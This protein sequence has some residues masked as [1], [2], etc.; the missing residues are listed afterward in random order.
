MWL[1]GRI[2]DRGSVIAVPSATERSGGTYAVGALPPPE[3]PFPPTLNDLNNLSYKDLV[4]LDEFYNLGLF[5]G[6]GIEQAADCLASC[7]GSVRWQVEIAK[8]HFATYIGCA[9]HMNGTV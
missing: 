5:G 9:V 7:P 2:Q 1:S 8:R 6:L 3:V 4:T